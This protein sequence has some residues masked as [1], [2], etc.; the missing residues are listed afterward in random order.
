MGGRQ[1]PKLQRQF[2][3]LPCLQ[4]TD[5]LRNLRV[6]QVNGLY[7]G[8]SCILAQLVGQSELTWVIEIG[9]SELINLLSQTSVALVPSRVHCSQQFLTAHSERPTTRH[10]DQPAVFIPMI[11]PLSNSLNCEKCLLVR[12]PG[13]FRLPKSFYNRRRKLSN[14]SDF[15]RYLIVEAR[16]P[17]ASV[18]E[19]SQLLKVSRGTVS[20]VITA[21][22]QWGRTSS[23]KRNRRRR[24]NGDGYVRI[25]ADTSWISAGSIIC[26]K[27]KVTEEKY[28]EI[29]ADQVHPMMQTLFPT[30]NGVFHDN[31]PIHATELVKSWFD[32]QGDEIKPWPTQPSDLT[33]NMTEPLL[34]ISELSIRNRYSPPTSLPEHLQYLHKECG[35]I[36]F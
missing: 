3:H 35:V 6:P 8:R 28:R 5:F 36:F 18:N 2:V 19:T 29:L 33:Y 1:S 34:S 24:K 31:V 23:T 9:F 25:S 21:Y 13:M 11:R 26:L 15:Q 22:P 30:G 17:R 32:E 10:F 7:G 20:K 14:L 16:L 27:G 4:E 12:L